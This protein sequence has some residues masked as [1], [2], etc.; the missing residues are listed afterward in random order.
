M[1]SPGAALAW[2]GASR[3]VPRVGVQRTSKGQPRQKEEGG[4]SS[5]AEITACGKL[6]VWGGGPSGL[7]G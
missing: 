1:G 5:Q 3:Q 6:E 4:E 7:R 2:S